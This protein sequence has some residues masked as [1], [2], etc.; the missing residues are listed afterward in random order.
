[1]SMISI[2]QI[3]AYLRKVILYLEDFADRKAVRETDFKKGKDF[4]KI[5]KM[6]G[7]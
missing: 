7:I 5:A 3:R 6:I 4:G 2:S 1:M